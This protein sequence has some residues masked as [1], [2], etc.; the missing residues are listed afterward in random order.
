[1]KRLS[2]LTLRYYN[3]E[4]SPDLKY[5]DINGGIDLYFS[6]QEMAR[7]FEQYLGEYNNQFPVLR[8]QFKFLD[9]GS[10]LLDLRELPFSFFPV[11]CNFPTPHALE[12]PYGVH[13]LMVGRSGNYF[14]SGIDVFHGLIDHSFRGRISVGMKFYRPN[15]YVFDS[16]SR[17]AQLTLLN[18]SSNDLTKLHLEKVERYE[19]L[20][21]TERGQ[22]GFG[23]S[24]YVKGEQ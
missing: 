1:M 16:N 11:L 22:A 15:K 10:L 12:F 9:D 4:P 14:K 6:P 5:D 3:F 18:Y 13:G 24:G 23:S 8:R 7:G 21:T 2:F 20:G 17:I 19:D